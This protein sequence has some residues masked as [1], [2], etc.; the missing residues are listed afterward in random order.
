MDMFEDK[1]RQFSAIN[2]NVRLKITARDS[3]VSYSARDIEV[4]VKDNSDSVKYQLVL[5]DFNGSTKIDLEGIFDETRKTGGYN[6]KDKDV[7]R[8]FGDFKKDFLPKLEKEEGVVL[9]ID[10]FNF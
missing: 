4:H 5:Y 2:S 7:K 9:K 6:V 3:T 1:I 8:L 10:W